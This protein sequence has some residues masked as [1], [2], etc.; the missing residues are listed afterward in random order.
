MSVCTQSPS[1]K[2]IRTFVCIDIPE[3]QREA[4]SGWMSECRRAADSN[5]RWVQPRTIHVTL[6]F[7][8]ER[9]IETVNALKDELAKIN[10]P[11]TL[12]I[13]AGGIGGFPN[14]KKPSVIWTRVLGDLD[15]LQKI[16]K[17][18]E[19][20]ANR[21]GIPKEPRPYTPH[22]TLARNSSCSPLPDKLIG[23][24]TERELKL[25]PWRV[26]EIILMKS[27]LLPSGPRYTPLALF[28]I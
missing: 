13:S 1:S 10:K 25:E 21:A 17:E 23:A 26:S 16:Q 8:G 15:S 9:T 3:K 20:A 18:V 12:T 7:C 11:E 28:K 4:I 6:K 5:L 24:M 22:L 2:L 14:L 19:F 27:E